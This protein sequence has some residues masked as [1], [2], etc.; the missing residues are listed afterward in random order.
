MLL[1]TLGLPYLQALLVDPT[2]ACFGS[3]TDDRSH[4]TGNH[5][6][7]C[8]SPELESELV[9]GEPLQRSLGSLLLL[10]LPSCVC[11]GQSHT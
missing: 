4:L 1:R 2:P 10:P 7:P 6:H 11:S 3:S 8:L 5:L 9:R